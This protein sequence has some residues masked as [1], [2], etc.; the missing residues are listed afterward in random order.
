MPASREQAT[1]VAVDRVACTGH[2]VCAA[3]LPRQITLD[4]W[5]YPIVAAADDPAV[6]VEAAVRLCPARALRPSR[7]PRQ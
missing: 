3:L 4:E 2:G 7:A 5:G 6:D 1:R